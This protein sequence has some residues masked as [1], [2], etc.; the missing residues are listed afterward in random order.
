MGSQPVVSST[1]L[2]MTMYES[3]TP[4]VVAA[5]VSVQ[6]QCKISASSKRYSDYLATPIALPGGTYVYEQTV[7]Y[8]SMGQPVVSLVP[9]PVVDEQVDY[10]MEPTPSARV[11]EEP[12]KPPKEAEKPEANKGMIQRVEDKISDGVHAVE[13]K[14]ADGVHAAVDAV[15]NVAH[16]VSDKVK[17][18]FSSVGSL[19]HRSKAPDD[20]TDKAGPGGTELGKGSSVEVKQE[21]GQT[22][23]GHVV[24]DKNK[25]GHFEIQLHTDDRGKT[26][27]AHESIVTHVSDLHPSVGTGVE[28]LHEG[29]WHTAHVIAM[30]SDASRGAWACQ[31]HNDPKGTIT[32]CNDDAMRP[33]LSDEEKEVV[34]HQL[35]KSLAEKAAQ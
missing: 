3:T 16:A 7:S 10:S 24:A 28:V 4:T 11:Q 34:T 22:L 6:D 19:F 20:K 23:R 26:V 15:E 2:P 17:G 21:D 8:N 9:R 29:E 32:Y 25:D 30:P 33:L 18:L 27:L 14:I 13:Q 31:C 1:A 5:D 35:S 12:E